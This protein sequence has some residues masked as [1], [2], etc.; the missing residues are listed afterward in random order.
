MVQFLGKGSLEMAHVLIVEDNEGAR[1]IL[2]RFLRCVGHTF[3]A[4]SDGR[5]AWELL[6]DGW[7]FDLI[8]SDHE[9]NEMS[10]VE[11]LQRVKANSRT[12]GIPF[13]LMSGAL[14]VSEGDQRG[15]KEVC[16]EL[17]ATFVEKPFFKFKELIGQ[18]LP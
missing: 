2:A 6:N 11:L 7:K 14:T 12:A 13:V 8:F 15:L 10:G 1:E 9:M 16:A 3:T 18:L 17:D 4:V 5:E